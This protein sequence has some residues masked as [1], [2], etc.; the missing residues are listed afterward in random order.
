MELDENLDDVYDELFASPFSPLPAD[1]Y[2]ADAHS[3]PS[4]HDREEVAVTKDDENEDETQRLRRLLNA[5][6][7]ER[8]KYVYEYKSTLGSS[9]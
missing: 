1:N 9:S 4:A 6:A 5:A 7:L 2:V 3:L 8:E